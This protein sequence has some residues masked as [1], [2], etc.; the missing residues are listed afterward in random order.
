MPD[1][2]IRETEVRSAIITAVREGRDFFVLQAYEHCANGRE[3]G[4]DQ[5]YVQFAWRD[6]LRLQIE[7]QGDPY[8]DEPYTEHQRGILRRLG[9]LP[10]FELGD[11]FANWVIMREAEG[12]EP[13]SVARLMIDT[14]RLVHSANFLDAET[15]RRCGVSYWTYEP[16]VSVTKRDVK[17]EI[18]RRYRSA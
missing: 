10:P 16:S 13:E 5:P 1:Q 8:R 2:R 11:D 17:A 14:L 3:P 4:D 18:L 6:D 7:T 15:A 9:Y 12:C